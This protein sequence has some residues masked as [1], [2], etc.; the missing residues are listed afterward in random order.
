VCFFV[1]SLLLFLL[2]VLVLVLLR[3]NIIIFSIMIII[4]ISIA[5]HKHPPSLT[6]AP[7]HRA[8]A[9]WAWRAVRPSAGT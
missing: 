5:T 4:I 3:S 1:H 7:F 9:W 2:L 8:V 6:L